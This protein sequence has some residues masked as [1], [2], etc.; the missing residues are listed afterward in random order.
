VG[1]EERHG[2]VLFVDI[3]DSTR[4]Y[5]TLGDEGARRVVLQ[6][7]DRLAD[8]VHGHG[9]RVID[10]IG[11]ELMC[12]FTSLSA[13][14]QCAVAMQRAVAGHRQASDQPDWLAVRIGLHYGPLIL[15]DGRVFGET[16]YTAKRVS[17]L[18]KG[19]QILTTA[20]TMGQI[21]E[22]LQVAA[23]MV[24]RTR[25]RGYAGEVD[26]HEVVWDPMSATSQL[27]VAPAVSQ[28]S[29]AR[30]TLV[31][32]DRATVLDPNQPALTIGRGE[33]CDLVVPGGSVS[34]LHARIEHR[35]GAFFLA[36][37]STN[38]TNVLPD[39]GLPVSLFHDE[40]RLEGSGTIL[41]GTESAPDGPTALGYRV[42]E[43]GCRHDGDA[44]VSG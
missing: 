23:R 30:L 4:L 34:R 32:G 7:L 21:G 9:G 19:E 39:K 31:R 37:M 42:E 35:S 8:T 6:C 29:W 17:S 40:H 25:L 12:V 27:R 3:A 24:R 33:H 2:G 16:V 18:A 44:E 20:A 28:T 38:G 11:D 43:A 10:R 1:R 14:L 36:D 5:R 15:E 41:L 22:R 13:T 26:L